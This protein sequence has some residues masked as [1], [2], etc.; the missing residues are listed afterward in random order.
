MATLKGIGFNQAN[1]RT[2]TG[3]TGDTVSFDV[4]VVPNATGTGLSVTNDAF[5]GGNLVVTGDI[6]SR[7]TSQLLVGDQFID[8]AVGNNTAVH[9][10][11]GY[12]GQVASANGFTEET[13]ASFTTAGAE[14]GASGSFQIT[15][16]F[17]G[18]TQNIV[19]QCLTINNNVA[20]TVTFNTG[21]A[22]EP[23]VFTGNS[24][25]MGTS[26]RTTVQTVDA[27]V[28]LFNS[29]VDVDGVTSFV[30]SKTGSDTVTFTS[31]S[32]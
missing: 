21:S 16:A 4:Q 28:V 12:T 8:L 30:V 14:N 18:A 22:V 31:K 6:T 20:L 19:T 1:A 23:T 5:V 7:S 24:A 11:V 26:G 13:S 25:T 15:G 3:S 9:L 27:L 17:A 32:W 29:K 2:T 10:P